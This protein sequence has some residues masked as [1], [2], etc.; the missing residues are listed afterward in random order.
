MKTKKKTARTTTKSHAR[1]TRAPR[2]LWAVVNDSIHPKHDAIPAAATTRSG[3][4]D[5]CED[6]GDRVV[7][8]YVLAERTRER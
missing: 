3:A 2:Q 4:R 5:L 6:D 8:P 7:G 1:T